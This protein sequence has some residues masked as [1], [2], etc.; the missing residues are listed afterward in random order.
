MAVAGPAR[1][2]DHGPG[3]ASGTGYWSAGSASYRPDLVELAL[4]HSAALPEVLGPADSAGMTPEGL[5]ISAGTGE[6][7]AA[8]FGLG[9]PRATRWCRWGPPGP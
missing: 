2:A 3:A 1:P 8:A 4:G 6:T 9:S 5:L 7:M